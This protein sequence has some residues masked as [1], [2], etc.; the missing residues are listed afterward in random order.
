M[1]KRA[2]K[3]LVHVIVITITYFYG[4]NAFGLD[5]M[6]PPS[7]GLKK[8][9][10]GAGAD[11]SD[12]RM[13]IDFRN[14]IIIDDIY[15][16][17]A[18]AGRT[19]TNIRSF[20][21]HHLKMHKGYANIGY[22]LTDDLEMFI[23]V[24]GMNTEFSGNLFPSQTSASEKYNGDTGFA[25]GFGTKVTFYKKDKLKLGGLFQMSRA[26]SEASL[27]ADSLPGEIKLNIVEMQIAVGPT[28]QLTDKIAI[29][30]GPFWHFINFNGSKIKESRN[31]AI[32]PSQA[33]QKIS[34]ASYDIDN[35][36]RFGVYIGAQF[37]F[38]KNTFYCIEYQHTADANALAMSVRWKF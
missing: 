20:T 4:V 15:Q 38:L 8:G 1:C 33:E 26:S 36:A 18:L 25:I 34:H 10:I 37:E 3:I 32:D 21:I 28:Y 14:G 6:G 22:G 35:I 24:G 27:D 17:G 2:E 29:Y 30:G 7:A 31:P 23:R 16:F 13:N 12:T 11:Y 5:M 9:Q 19:S